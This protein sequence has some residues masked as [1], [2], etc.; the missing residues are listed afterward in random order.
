MAFVNKEE[1]L[2]KSTKNAEKELEEA[3]EAERP[4]ELALKEDEDKPSAEDSQEEGQ[5]EELEAEKTPEP[6]QEHDWQKR[7]NDLRRWVDKKLRP[8][9]QGKIDDLNGKLEELSTKVEDMAK[10][11]APAELPESAGEI[12]ALKEDNPAAYNAITAMARQIAEDIVKEKTKDI[13]GKL[14][15]IEA[16]QVRNAE[17][18]AF[19]KLQRLHPELDLK[20]LAEGLDSRFNDWADTKSERF[21]SPLFDQKEDV[22][23]ASDVLTAYKKETGLKARSPKKGSQDVSD[24]S[25]ASVPKGDKGY[26]YRESDIQNMSDR[27]LEKHMEKIEEAELK[28]RIF[29]DLSGDP[30]KEQR[31]LGAMAA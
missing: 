7:Y 14:Q 21:L 2:E 27:D 9:Y 11:G 23:A 22:Q 31:R 16:Q 20:E 17:E 13:S 8:E 1:Y 26:D 15:Q 18:A 3:I 24:K 25:A 29:Y 5:E 28:G 12:E 6:K 4:E 30:V 19:I 10:S